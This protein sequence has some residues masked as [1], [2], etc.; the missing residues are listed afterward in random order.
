[1]T[2]TKAD[3]SANLPETQDIVQVASGETVLAETENSNNLAL[4]QSLILAYN[5]IIDSGADLG[6]TNSFTSQQTFTGGLKAGQIDP[7][8]ANGTVV[9]NIGSGDFY[10]NTVAGSNAY[11][12][13]GQIS[14]LINSAS[15]AVAM[16]GSSSG[17]AGT[18]GLTP[19]NAAGTQWK[20][21]RG[22][23]TWGTQLTAASV[24]TSGFTVAAGNLYPVD[25]TG[26]A[27]T[28]IFPASASAGDM[29]GIVDVGGAI[30]TNNITFSRNGLEIMNLTE[31]MTFDVNYGRAYF[32]YNTSNGWLLL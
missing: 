12:T 11:Q 21:L 6:L 28:I 26:G 13:L 17:A 9:M 3:I 25:S 5:W 30:V 1:M 15:G 29:F 2:T 18:S 7:L 8:V 32:V 4:L 22:D 14:T 19:A 20:V 10:K 31:N 24:Q 27:F 16:T 23:A